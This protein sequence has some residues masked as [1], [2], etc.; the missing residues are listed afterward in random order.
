MCAYDLNDVY[1]R[2]FERNDYMMHACEYCV[3]TIHMM[4]VNI[5]TIKTTTLC[6]MREIKGTKGFLSKFMI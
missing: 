1:V 6:P 2:E 4:H 3:Y 5:Y